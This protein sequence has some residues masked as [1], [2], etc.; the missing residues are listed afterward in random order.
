MAGIDAQ[1]PTSLCFPALSA[2]RYRLDDCQRR[3]D[4]LAVVALKH[5]ATNERAEDILA[6]L[7]RVHLAVEQM[8]AQLK[9][10]I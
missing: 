10:G 2:V 6:E 1:P 8:A 5:M 7:G 4:D 9:Q 3:I